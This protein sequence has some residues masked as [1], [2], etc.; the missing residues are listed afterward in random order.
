MAAVE[1]LV[2]KSGQL[3]G[4][5]WAL[6]GERWAI[7]RDPSYCAIVLPEPEISR[8]H[9]E[10]VRAEDG[11]LWVSDLGSR[12][13]TWLNGRPLSQTRQPLRPGDELLLAGKVALVLMTADETASLQRPNAPPSPLGLVIEHARRSVW[14]NGKELH[15][16]LSVQQYQVLQLLVSRNGSVVSRD[17]LLDEMDR[18]SEHSPEDVHSLQAL[19]ALIHRLRERLAELDPDH[20]YIVT[21]R[22]HGFRFVNRSL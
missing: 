21:V 6:E 14:I 12:N 20:D 7:G 5:R 11:S 18:L 17:E 13:G 8:R 1:M 19:N 16:P 2:V 4:Q 10:I 22:G 9:V 15:P 3:A